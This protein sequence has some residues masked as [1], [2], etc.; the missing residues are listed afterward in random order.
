MPPRPHLNLVIGVLLFPFLLG[1]SSA[2]YFFGSFIPCLGRRSLGTTNTS[3]SMDIHNKN[4]ELTTTIATTTRT[5]TKRLI[6]VRHGT[7]VANEYMNRPGNQWGD[8]TFHD[9]GT[10]QDARL[11]HRGE[12]QANS[13]M[14]QLLQDQGQ[15]SSSCIL[16]NVELVVVSPLTRA[17]QTMELGI[18]PFL[19]KTCTATATA[20]PI[21]LAHPDMTERVY[22]S[23]DT[24]RPVRVL[25]EEFPNIDFGLLSPQQDQWWYTGDSLV[26]NNEQYEEWRPFGQGQYYA[27]PG[28]PESVFQQRVKRFQKWLADRPEHTIVLVTHWAILKEWTGDEF[29]NGECRIIEWNYVQ[30]SL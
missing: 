17:I 21:I 3:M 28:E 4:K 29:Y 9:D 6:L 19:S 12:Q 15:P 14:S 22:T 5:S 2:A 30:E 13:M 10:M 26:A 23:S 8:A 20:T 27:V 25:Q 1:S 18:R 24:G 11:S 16:Q 7:S